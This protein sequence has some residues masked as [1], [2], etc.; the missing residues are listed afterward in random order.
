MEIIPMRTNAKKLICKT[1]SFL[2]EGI[3]LLFLFLPS[4]CSPSNSKVS[5]SVYSLQTLHIIPASPVHAYSLNDEIQ[6]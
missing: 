6:N 3:L 1:T 4:L 5:F 2:S